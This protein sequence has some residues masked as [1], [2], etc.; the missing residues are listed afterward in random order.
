MVRSDYA[1][2]GVCFFFLGGWLEQAL[3]Y[4]LCWPKAIIPSEIGPAI[5]ADFQHLYPAN[6]KTPTCCP[7][8]DN[9]TKVTNSVTSARSLWWH[10]RPYF[11][12]AAVTRT[13]NPIGHYTSDTHS[14]LVFTRYTENTLPW[15]MAQPHVSFSLINSRHSSALCNMHTSRQW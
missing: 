15:T 14:A 2:E 3:H 1:N 12:P 11:W 6:A 8:D 10:V 4:G 5:R 7:S 9:H 13:A